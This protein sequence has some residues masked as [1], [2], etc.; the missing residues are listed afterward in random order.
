M[1]LEELDSDVLSTDVE[2]QVS[3]SD[4]STISW[5][6]K[7][8]VEPS[9]TQP[10]D[11]SQSAEEDDGHVTSKAS[12]NPPVKE[13]EA[14]SSVNMKRPRFYFESDTLA[15][16]N[17]PEYVE[18]NPQTSDVTFF[19]SSYCQLLKT[20]A[21]LEAQKMQSIRVCEG[22][23][24]IWVLGRERGIRVRDGYEYCIV[25]WLFLQDIESLLHAQT[26]AE[27]DPLGF[28]QALRNGVRE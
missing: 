7:T 22:Q 14:G 2:P 10:S 12:S 13:E 18:I 17:N 23:R 20:L 25:I 28:I 19:L 1:E 26:K 4:P 24:S 16:K 3:S 27:S 5:A 6:V 11:S 21:I 8:P 15:L 9:S